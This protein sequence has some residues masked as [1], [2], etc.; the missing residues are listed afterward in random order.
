M[1]L[2]QIEYFLM[3]AD[4]KNFSSAAK[5]LYVS[6]LALSKQ[7][8]N[9]EE[10]IGTRLFSR[11]PSGV[12]LTE[13]G[14]KLEE[15]LR[16]IK[17]DLNHAKLTAASIGQGENQTIRVGCFD[18]LYVEDFL[19]ALLDYIKNEKPKAR[20][21]IERNSVEQNKRN[22]LDNKIDLLCTLKEEWIEDARINGVVLKKR[23][24]AIIFSEKLFAGQQQPTCLQ[25]FSNK[26][27]C[28]PINASNSKAISL[29]QEL[30][31]NPLSFEYVT[32]VQTAQTNVRMGLGFAI[33]AEGIARQQPELKCF[34]LP[35][36]F[37]IDIYC[38]WKQDHPFMNDLMNH[39]M[40]T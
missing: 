12:F 29:L 23:K 10:E 14:I 24:A 30:F 37:N 27:F 20:I 5:K 7:I 32:N 15:D 9:L 35:D 28:S 11:T 16:R 19:P 40:E 13:A 17:E 25:D 34:A 8:K 3:V 2:I 1:K 22:L 6:Q 21:K 33:L 4:E 36:E 38:V 31:G 26:T 18:G 39:H